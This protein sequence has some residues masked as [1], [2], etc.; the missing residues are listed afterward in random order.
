MDSSDSLPHIYLY[1]PF[2]CV[3][4]I[5]AI[6]DDG[7]DV[8]H[9]NL[10]AKILGG[11][12]NFEI[13]VDDWGRQFSHGSH[14]AGIAAAVTI[15]TIIMVLPGLN[16]RHE[17]IQETFLMAMATQHIVL[18]IKVLAKEEHVFQQNKVL[19]GIVTE[20]KSSSDKA[21]TQQQLCKRGLKKYE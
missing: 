11:D 7:V 6:I 20:T 2:G 18:Y 3:V 5:I 16:G 17:Y 13:E 9:N 10:N 4:A 8:N 19:Y 21:C 15:T 14:V 1:Y 12:N